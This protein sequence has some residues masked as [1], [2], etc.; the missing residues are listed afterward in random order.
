M[1]K[2][3]KQGFA[4]IAIFIYMVILVMAILLP[5][6]DPR[7]FIYSIFIIFLLPTLMK[8]LDRVTK[9]LEL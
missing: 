3:I 6:Q 2:N 4:I 9:I 7:W 8:Y 5:F 1:N